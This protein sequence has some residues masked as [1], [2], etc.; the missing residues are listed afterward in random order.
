M[1]DTMVEPRVFIPSNQFLGKRQGHPF[2]RWPDNFPP[3][4]SPWRSTD[5]VT[6]A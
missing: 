3:R 5:C 1:L 2:P 6:A 4:L